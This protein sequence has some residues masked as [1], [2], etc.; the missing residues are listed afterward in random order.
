MCVTVM[1]VCT[2]VCIVSWHTYMCYVCAGTKCVC[3]VWVSVHVYYGGCVYGC[4]LGEERRWRQS[5]LIVMCVCCWR[6]YQL[7][8]LK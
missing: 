3:G 7:T 5:V 4:V 1:F 6:Y 2:S 8:D